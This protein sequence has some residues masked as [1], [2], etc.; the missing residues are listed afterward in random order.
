MDLSDDEIDLYSQRESQMIQSF[1]S[2]VAGLSKLSHEH[3]RATSEEFSLI[4]APL[5]PKTATSYDNFLM[6]RPAWMELKAIDMVIRLCREFGVRSHIVHL[7]TAAA[8]P[9]IEEAKMEGLPLTV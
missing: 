3:K 9:M 5:S 2:T 8:L 4:K 1:T 7:S 6:S